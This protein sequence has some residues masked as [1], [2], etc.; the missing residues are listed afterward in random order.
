MKLTTSNTF[1][2]YL[3]EKNNWGGGGPNGRISE[4]K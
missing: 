4:S 3:I 2:L 1:R